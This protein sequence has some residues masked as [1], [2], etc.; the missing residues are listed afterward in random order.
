MTDILPER[1]EDRDAVETLF[2]LTFAP[3]RANLSSYQ[4]RVGVAPVTKLCRIARDE[5]D[6]VVGAIRYWPI[7]IGAP[8]SETEIESLL[9][10]PVAVHPTRQSEGLGSRLIVDS[11][12]QAATLGWRACL[13][14]GDEPYYRRFGFRRA[15]AER[16]EFPAP[17]NP[18]RVLGLELTPDALAEAVGPVRRWR[19]E[20]AC[21]APRRRG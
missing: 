2:D 12:S 21:D 10:G 8:G 16:I 14:V 18:K 9:L 7:L 17:T 4:L 15:L 3:G 5:F 20:A 11:L 6:M 1:I 19:D 13:L